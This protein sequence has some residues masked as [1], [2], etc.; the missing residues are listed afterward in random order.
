M[1]LQLN[2]PAI[3]NLIVSIPKPISQ[4]LIEGLKKVLKAV[5]KTLLETE[6][7]SEIRSLVDQI[8]TKLETL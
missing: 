4:R 6:E 8:S 7:H 1:L 2:D 3:A 5:K